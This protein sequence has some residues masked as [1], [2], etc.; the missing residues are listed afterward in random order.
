[1]AEELGFVLI[2][3]Y[4]IRKMRTGGILSRLLRKPG[5][6]LIETRIFSPGKELA[7]AFAD[8]IAK[9]ATEPDLRVLVENYVRENYAPKKRGEPPRVLFLLFKGEN[10][11]ARIREEVGVITPDFQGGQT[12]RDTY[13]DI[14]KN[15]KGEVVY[16]EPAVL[17]L[18][19][20]RRVKE[21]MLIWAKYTDECGGLIETGASKE[22]EQTLVLLKPDNFQWPSSRVGAIIDHFSS[23]GLNM[24]GMKVVHM[25][26][27]MAEN[28]YEPVRKLF[29]ERF[30]DIVE[31]KI[32]TALAKEF[33]ID[34]PAGAVAD[35][36][37]QMQEE[38]AENQFS[39]I[40]EFMTGYD[41]NSLKN[42]KDRRKPG[43]EKCLAIVYEGKNAVKKIRDILGATDPDKAAPGTI[44]NI[45]GKDI[46][47]NS[48]HA[49]DSV[50]N[51]KREMAIIDMAYSDLKKTIENFYKTK[52]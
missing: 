21:K 11:V 30:R 4:T 40:I 18:P 35:M 36:A 20:N 26:V 39:K 2:N 41:P 52:K 42:A 5:L 14:I 28:F 8:D 6:D 27:A 46:M 15:E 17:I 24:I 31:E 33:E 38:Y 3:P 9:D 34:L 22:S 45:F 19:D 51:T 23:S 13:A 43:T 29:S 50:E 48:A 7:E 47:V 10:A 12:I 1:M 32:T 16:F 49:S 25:S 37:A 44:R